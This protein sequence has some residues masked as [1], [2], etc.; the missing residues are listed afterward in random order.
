VAKY[1]GCSYFAAKD[2]D[3]ARGRQIIEDDFGMKLLV[4]R[5]VEEVL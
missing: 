4:G 3:F 5:E 2:S 1:Y